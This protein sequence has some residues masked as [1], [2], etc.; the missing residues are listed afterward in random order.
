MLKKWQLEKPKLIIIQ[1]QLRGL[2]NPC[3][4]R[5]DSPINDHSGDCRL[6]SRAKPSD[7]TVYGP[8]VQRPQAIERVRL[9]SRSPRRR[10]KTTSTTTSRRSASSGTKPGTTSGG[11]VT[12]GG[13]TFKFYGNVT[14]NFHL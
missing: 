6:L 4:Q 3:E 11:K 7:H 10:S 8:T 1:F 2:G 12:R 14:L 13:M 5:D 9:R